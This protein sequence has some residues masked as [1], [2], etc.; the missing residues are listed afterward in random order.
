MLA[1]FGVGERFYLAGGTALALMYSHR[2][3]EDFDFFAEK[4]DLRFCEQ[5]KLNLKNAGCGISSVCSTK[6]TEIFLCNGVKLSFFEY[7]YPLLLPIRRITVSGGKISLASDED[8]A[9]MKAVAVMQR[10]TKR[11]FYDLYFLMS[12]HKWD[13]RY[14]IELCRKKY[15]DVFSKHHFLKAVVYFEDAEQDFCEEAEVVWE[16]IKEFFRKQ[17]ESY[18]E[19]I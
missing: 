15:G 2:Y 5:L 16:D 3:S 1:R 7:P 12:E 19:V 11:D 18:L 9:C 10:G 14:L 17:V 13:L 4:M 8:I 6:D